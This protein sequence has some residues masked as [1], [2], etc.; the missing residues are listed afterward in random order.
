MI[1]SVSRLQKLI[2]KTVKQDVVPE[3]KAFLEATK[4]V[5]ALRNSFQHA[6]ERIRDAAPF[7]MPGVPPLWGTLE[8]LAPGEDRTKARSLSI[9]PGTRTFRWAT[10][11][12]VGSPYPAAPVDHIALTAFGVEVS[13]TRSH[14]D[15]V[16]LARALEN[17][18]PVGPPGLTF[19]DLVMIATVPYDD[20]LDSD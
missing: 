10:S 6:E 8:C 13:L 17:T 20:V 15:I 18:V 5:R 12:V 9:T 2:T 3:A 1:D 14:G 4:S 19:T 16:S 11:A 7:P